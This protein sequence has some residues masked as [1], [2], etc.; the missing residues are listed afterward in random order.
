MGSSVARGAAF[1][2]SVAVIYRVAVHGD[3]RVTGHLWLS[4]RPFERD[5]DR[6]PACEIGPGQIRE[7]PS[8]FFRLLRQ[9][10]SEKRVPATV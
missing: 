4:R 2:L 3:P 9:F 1:L 7:G 8:F 6:L 5:F 10:L